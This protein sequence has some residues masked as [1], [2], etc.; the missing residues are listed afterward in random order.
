MSTEKE[1]ETWMDNLTIEDNIQKENIPFYQYSEFENVK[2]IGRNVYKATFKTSQKTVDLKCVYLNNKI[3]QDNLINEVEIKI[4]RKLEIH[5]SFLKF[6]GIT[7]KENTDNYMIILEYANHGFLCQN[8]KTNFQ[9]MEKLNLAKQ[10]T[11][12]LMYLHSN[13]IIHGKLNSE[14]IFIHNGNI[15]VF[16]L[17]KTIS[18]S[19]RFLTNNLGPI[20]YMDPQHLERFNTIGKNKSSD[21]FGLG[22]FLWEIS[23][24]CWKHNGSS[25][26][27]ISQV[28]KNLSEIIISDSSVEFET[29]QLEKSKKQNKNLEVKPDPPFVCASAEAVV[30]IRDLFK[31]FIDIPTKQILDI[32][33]TTIENYIREHKKKNPAKILYEMIRYPSHYWFTS[34]IGFF[35][36][37]GI[38]TVV[39]NQMA[40][41]FFNLAAN[42]IIDMNNIASNLLI[43]K[44]YKVNKEMGN[45]YLAH[46]YL[47]GIGVEKDLKKGFQIYS[48]AADK[49]S[50]RA[51]NCMAYCYHN[52]L[53][54]EK[55]DKKAF[56]LYL[57]SAEKGN[58]V[59]Q[60]NV[61]FCYEEGI[62]ITI[63]ETK[64][65][66]CQIKSACAG[67][68]DAMYNVG[69]S[70]DNGI[71]VDKDE[72][73]ALKW[74]LKAAEK[75][76]PI[77]QNYLGN[78]Y[79]TSYGID[80]NEVKA[81]EWFK[82]A[83]ENNYTSSQYSL[84]RCFYEGYG[85]KKDFINAIYWLNK[86][87]KGG[88]IY[89]NILLEEIIKKTTEKEFRKENF[90]FYQYSTFKTSQR[91]ALKCVCLNDKFALENLIDET[92]KFNR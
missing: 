78:F 2:L 20:Q 30:F 29:V 10:M 17:I 51:L 48:K 26:P 85:T 36:Q 11:N 27:C 16:E 46:M 92:G 39:D 56:E 66:Q 23:S 84:G 41:K 67:S 24:D 61:G 89:A 35:Y 32:Q 82:K 38:G 90:L 33:Q 58:L 60:S 70:Y 14:N 28:V 19:L 53:G 50:N 47:D 86:A 79:E 77:A 59:A 68:I 88:N 49:G 22:I 3:T 21:I 44:F 64:G 18:D 9:K 43:R 6:Y 72:K 76:Y 83:A 13:D 34:L 42:E 87:K 37:H 55:H 57:K 54:V 40:F 69:H 8:S 31:F 45:I 74:Y 12:I 52:G 5:D 80:R 91:I 4:H 81:F 15:D 73:E 1:L 63:D 71:G 65:F 75:G 7:K 25:R 62:G